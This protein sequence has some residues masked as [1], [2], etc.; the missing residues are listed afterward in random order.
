MCKTFADDTSLFS[1]VKYEFFSDTQLNNDLNK[2]SEWT[3]QWKILFNP[4][5]SKQVIEIC[6]SHKR[7]NENYRSWVFND[8]KV[9]LPTSQ[10]HLWLILDSKT[11]FNEHINNKINNCNNII[12]KMKRLFLSP[13][14]KQ[15]ANNIQ[16]LRQA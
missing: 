5:P 7:D 12:D 16:I 14:K 10:K 1:K 11:D 2:I 8:T 4:Y 3:F 6:C 9:Q 15:L 13:V